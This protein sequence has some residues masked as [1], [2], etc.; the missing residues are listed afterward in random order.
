MNKVFI[1]GL[2]TEEEPNNVRYIGK[3]KKNLNKR[4]NEHL[5]QYDLKN[6][7]HKA[8][9]LKSILKNNQHPIIIEIDLVPEE[10]WQSW[11]IYWISQFKA[12]GFNL[13]NIGIGGEGG[14]ATEETKVKISAKLK[15]KKSR[16]GKTFTSEQR[17]NISNG[18]KGRKLTEEHIKNKSKGCFKSIDLEKLKIE[19]EKVGNYKKLTT[20]FN[21]SESKI[22]RTLKEHKLI[23]ERI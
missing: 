8:N 22:Y 2:A 10:E 15:G 13:T 16:L 12:W 1:Y 7:T 17:L 9:W 5:N 23:K 18:L 11:E 4:L 14:N 6:N 3:T 20:I 21:L 19:Y